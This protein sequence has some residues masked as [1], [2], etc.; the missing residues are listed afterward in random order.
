[1]N[2]IFLSANSMKNTKSAVPYR[3]GGRMVCVCQTVQQ[4]HSYCCKGFLA[5]V[6]LCGAEGEVKCTIT[7][8]RIHQ[9]L[10]CKILVCP[11][12]QQL[13]VFVT[14]PKSSDPL[15]VKIPL[16]AIEPCTEA[17]PAHINPPTPNQTSECEYTNCSS[18]CVSLK[19]MSFAKG[20]RWSANRI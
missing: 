1:M 11:A 7:K 18:T 6:E 4:F 20:D 15:P 10:S 9:V 19:Y 3:H 8:Y 16:E 2:S 5:T 13:H 14:Q 12:C 17:G